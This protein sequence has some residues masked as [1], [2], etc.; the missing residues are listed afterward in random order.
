MQLPRA[1]RF[2]IS[3]TSGG[4]ACEYLEKYGA[5]VTQVEPLAPQYKR[6]AIVNYMAQTQ[7]VKPS[8]NLPSHAFSHG[9]PIKLLYPA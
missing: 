7:K 2:I 3:A 5:Q 6:V 8:L 1:C 4:E 9:S